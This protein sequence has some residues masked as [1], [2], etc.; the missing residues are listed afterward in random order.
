MTLCYAYVG[1]AALSA[2]AGLSGLIQSSQDGGRLSGGVGDP[3]FTA[4]VLVSAVALALFM[5]LAPGRSRLYRVVLLGPVGLCVVAVFL[6]QSRGGVVALG[7]VFVLAILFGGRAR[8]QIVAVSLV[9]GSIAADLPRAP[10]AA[11][12]VFAAELDLRAGGGTGQNRPVVDR[13]ARSSSATRSKESGSRTSRSFRRST[14]SR[15]TPICRA[16]TSS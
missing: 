10:G 11:A 4:A 12:C 3:N 5:A 8:A 16:R 1:G 14:P 7:V 9:V 15:R 13:H 6:T 2:V